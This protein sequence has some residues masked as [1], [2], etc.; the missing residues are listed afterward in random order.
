[1]AGPRASNTDV[2]A[3]SRKAIVE[4]C[5]RCGGALPAQAR[6]CAFCAT[7]TGDPR[8]AETD[9]TQELPVVV[10]PH[11]AGTDDLVV[12]VTSSGRQPRRRLPVALVTVGIVIAIALL[13]TVAL[14]DDDRS[15]VD[16]AVIV[17]AASAAA[18]TP[19]V[20]AGE[21]TTLE[22]LRRAGEAAPAA[23]ASVQSQLPEVGR[24][25]DDATRL[26]LSSFVEAEIGLLGALAR[27]ASLDEGQSDRWPD[28]AADG[29][30]ALRRVTASALALPG[31]IGANTET[32]GADA[33]RALPRLEK[34]LTTISSRL[35][36][37]RAE[38]EKTSETRESGRAALEGY[39]APFRAQ[40]E[41]YG[42]LRG[43]VADYV[44]TIVGKTYAD[45][46][47]EFEQARED[48]QEVREALSGFTAPEGV[49]AAHAGVNAVVD[50]SVGALDAAV[51]GLQYSLAY[52]VP[53]ATTEGWR[54][55]QAE[56]DGISEAWRAAVAAWD[57]AIIDERARLDAIDDPP[58]PSI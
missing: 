32:I 16:P 2:G 34:T 49:A 43:R 35:G 50:R 17:A 30:N 48:R 27:L 5:A 42:T 39:A 46:Y 18:D 56:S 36:A 12:V 44:A 4:F 40:M 33:S 24:V 15:A 10:A 53:Y 26:A 1:M 45:A 52:G 31:S 37:W 38:V 8:A 51:E 13:T 21:A 29:R 54:R 3:T 57:K 23:I 19:W 22:Q 28:V 9:P 6:F 14:R 25:K 47:R 58:R 20:L 55:F 11:Q 7:P 41:Q